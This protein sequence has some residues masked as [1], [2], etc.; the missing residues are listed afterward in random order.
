MQE[1]ACALSIMRSLHAEPFPKTLEIAKDPTSFC[2]NKLRLELLQ[3]VD[4]INGVKLK[5]S[6]IT[7]SEL[8]I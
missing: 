2:K 7:F 1:I 4:E 5:V 3:S 8:F 6:R